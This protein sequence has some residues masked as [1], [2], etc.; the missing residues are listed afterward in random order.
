MRG[1]GGARSTQHSALAK[2]TLSPP[3]SLDRDLRPKG[4][5]DGVGASSLP[6]PPSLVHQHISGVMPSPHQGNHSAAAVY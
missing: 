1:W 3:R 2:R 4:H 5:T 6:R